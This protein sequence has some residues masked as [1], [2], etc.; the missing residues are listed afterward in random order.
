MSIADNSYQDCSC[1]YHSLHLNVPV[2][3][4]LITNIPKRYE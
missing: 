4:D 1:L 3:A 2:I